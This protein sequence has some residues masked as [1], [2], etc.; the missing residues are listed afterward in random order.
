MGL[1]LVTLAMIIVAMLLMAVGVF[2]NYRCLRGSCGNQEIVGFEEEP[3]RCAAC[4]KRK[5]MA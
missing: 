5:A 4:P 1:F 3:L 2:L